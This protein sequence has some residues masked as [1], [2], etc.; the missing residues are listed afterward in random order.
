MFED[1]SSQYVHQ[2]YYNPQHQQQPPQQQPNTFPTYYDPNNF[3]NQQVLMAAGQQLFTNPM[4]SAAIDH[5]SQSIVNKGKSWVG[6]NVRMF[7][8]KIRLMF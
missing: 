1:T 4:A 6:Q 5:Y 8:M 7:V 3:I 2:D